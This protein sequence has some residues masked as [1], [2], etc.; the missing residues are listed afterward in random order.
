[1]LIGAAAF[2]N[3]GIKKQERYGVTSRSRHAT[4]NMATEEFAL[5][6]EALAGFYVGYEVLA[7]PQPTTWEPKTA[8][9]EYL[10]PLEI[11]K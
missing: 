6:E 5:L 1:M 4:V 10:K 7:L 11:Y 8:C 9:K 2:T 3:S